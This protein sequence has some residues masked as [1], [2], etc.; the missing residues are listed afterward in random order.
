M[1]QQKRI[2]CLGLMASISVLM[3]VRSSAGVPPQTSAGEKN[4]AVALPA[5]KEELLGELSAEAKLE[6]DF[7]NVSERI[8]FASADI[9]P[10][11]VIDPATL[12]FAARAKE[13]KSWVLVVDGQQRGPTFESLKSVVLSPGGQHIVYS[14][15]Q[16]GH[17]VRVLD[18]KQLGP[19]S[20]KLDGGFWFWGRK[21]AHYHSLPDF[22]VPAFLAY[23]TRPER[24][25][26]IVTDIN[27]GLEFDEVDRPVF[28]PDGQRL[29]YTAKIAKKR[30]I[31]VLD[32]KEGPEFEEVGAPRFS[33]DGKRLAYAAR[34]GKKWFVVADGE[35]GP[36]FAEVSFPCFSP[37][38]RHLAYAAFSQRREAT[39]P[40]GAETELWVMI[41]DGKRGPEFEELGPPVFSPDG[42]H[43]AYWGKRTT[44]E[45]RREAL[46]L[47]GV[48]ATSFDYVG[49]PV[50]SPDSRHW[51]IGAKR[52]KS[53][54]VIADGK[55]VPDLVWYPSTPPVYSPDSQHIGTAGDWPKSPGRWADVV[56]AGDI[57]FS[58]D[59]RR[60]AYVVGWGG[61]QFLEG[62][63]TRARRY[64]VVDGH[65]GEVYDTLGV[66]LGFSPDSRHFIYSIRGGVGKD[67]S[68]V[69]TDGQ[70]GKLYDDVIGGAFR[71][72]DAG[73]SPTQF[74]Y[75][76]R[77]GR[78]F[79]RVTQPLR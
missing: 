52:A 50:F 1:R 20:E 51:A 62:H 26:P 61:Q 5:A 7:D 31:I 40:G 47:D 13:G 12:R 14:G 65:A 60:L 41:V 72:G 28:S 68:A 16:G 15:K 70:Q 38:G 18:D 58:S 44:Y 56:F 79:Y 46:M 24:K 45:G 33:P 23:S 6:R 69:V 11:Y 4:Q 9:V 27:V 25:W 57:T 54:V 39:T 10:A 77:E 48:K 29:A 32:G 63:T 64:V 17:W 67:K 35:P 34:Q 21:P 30:E 55:E 78:K 2:F 42:Q 43:V 19:P 3:S 76:A 59:G 37:D 53:Y 66:D 36:Q 8:K 22:L 73:A 74:I 49:Q 71:D 75:I